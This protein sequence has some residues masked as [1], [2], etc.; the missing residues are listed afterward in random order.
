MTI[1]K[2]L[3]A[4]GMYV[5]KVDLRI[6]RVMLE[7]ATMQYQNPRPPVSNGETLPREGWGYPSP[8]PLGHPRRIVPDPSPKCRLGLP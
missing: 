2:P 4:V 6:I 7:E 5:E 3:L 1:F 8:A